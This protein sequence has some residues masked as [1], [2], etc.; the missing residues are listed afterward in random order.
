M[1]FILIKLRSIL[2]LFSIALVQLSYAQVSSISGKVTDSNTGEPLIGVT[3][4]VEGT[5]LGTIT[6]I[7]GNYSINVDPEGATLIFSFIG[8]EPQKV[9]VGSNP[10]IN[11][12]MS[13]STEDI[14]E[15]VIIGYG[16]VKKEDATG[17]VVAINADDFNQGAITSPQELVTGKIA[18]LQIKSGGVA[19]VSGS[20]ISIRWSTHRE[21]WYFWYA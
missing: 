19:P 3:I 2:V 6:D 9:I 7:D 12:S 16:Q 1:K 15:V 8:Y 20:T 13:A 14:G 21:R 5:T 10:N 17:S 11:V 18:G 4:Q